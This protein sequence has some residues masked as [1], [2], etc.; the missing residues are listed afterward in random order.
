MFIKYIDIY[1]RCRC[2]KF[3]YL[4]APPT[5]SLEC[6]PFPEKLWCVHHCA[7]EGEP[8]F[9]QLEI[10]GEAA[11]E[12]S[13]LCSRGHSHSMEHSRS[14]EQPLRTAGQ[15]RARTAL[16]SAAPQFHTHFIPIPSEVL[17]ESYLGEGGGGGPPDF[18]AQTYG[19]SLHTS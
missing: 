2:S 10:C 11:Q 19:T 1:S 9:L 12:L 16:P 14:M 6:G 3:H 18:F 4:T 8:L 7:W 17:E 15:P 13:G 5:L